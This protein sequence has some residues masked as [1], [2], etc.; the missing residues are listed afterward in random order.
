MNC[1][2]YYEKAIAEDENFAE[3]YAG[4]AN[5]WL[6]LS[7]WGFYNSNEGFLKKGIQFESIGN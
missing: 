5:A 6:K 3:A 4:L 7:A 2:Q 1:I